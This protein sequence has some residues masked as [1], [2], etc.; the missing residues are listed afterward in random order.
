MNTTRFPVIFAIGCGLVF[1]SGVQADAPKVEFPAASPA[2]TLKQ[3]VGLT[4]IEIDYSRPGVKDRE[5]FGG[6]IPYDKVWRT[7]AN[8][9]TKIIF[10][11]AVKLNGTDIPAGT[12]AL[13]TI[14]G[15]DEWTIIINKGSEQ[16]GAYKYDEKVDVARFKATPIKLPRKIETFTINIDDVK[17]DSS[18]IDLVWDNVKVPIKLKVDFVDKLTSEIETVMASDEKKK[19]YFQAAQFYY[20][21]GKDLKKAKT[22]IDLAL[23]EREAHYMMYVKAEIL[24]KMGDKAGAIAAA[25]RSTELAEK[26]NDTG[27]VKLN[28]DLI[29]SLM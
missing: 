17:D 19:P 27:Y 14:P 8:S 4:D 12:Y 2:C 29:K 25:K 21:H 23:A 13:M 6:M 11:T 7:G 9:A 22:W 10:S 26:A 15:N 18:D 3:R 20:N 24:A 28:A 16:W 5:I 1:A